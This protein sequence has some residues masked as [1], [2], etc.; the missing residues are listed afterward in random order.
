MTT[1]TFPV[2]GMRCAH[3]KAQ[4][5]TALQAL[6]GVANVHASLDDKNVE[7]EF[8]DTKVTANTMKNAV[9]EVG[10]DLEA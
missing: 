10:F 5:E 7:V 3:C 1:K 4:V 8:D 9:A 6:D 2:Y